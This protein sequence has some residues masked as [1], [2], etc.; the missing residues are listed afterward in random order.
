MELKLSFVAS[1]FA[2][3]RFLLFSLLA[4]FVVLFAAGVS[5]HKHGTAVGFKHFFVLSGS[6]FKLLT[7]ISEDKK[8]FSHSTEL[9]EG[10][11]L[12]RGTCEIHKFLL[13]VFFGK[14]KVATF[15]LPQRLLQSG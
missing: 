9:F 1:S 15:S 6:F 8:C 2:V 12:S 4:N 11:K 14:R 3:C 5:G 10:V 13:T 7:T